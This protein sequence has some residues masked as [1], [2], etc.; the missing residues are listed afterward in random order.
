MGTAI[1]RAARVHV[2]EIGCVLE[3]GIY[4]PD[5]DFTGVERLKHRPDEELL[6]RALVQTFLDHSLCIAEDTQ[7]G[8]HLVFPSQYRREKDIPHEPDI[9]V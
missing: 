3:A 6:L 8:R 9:F 7:Y 2:D 5:F 1:I 4:R